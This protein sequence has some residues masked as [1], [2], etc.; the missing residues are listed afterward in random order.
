MEGRQTIKVSQEEIEKNICVS[1]C[2]FRNK[3]WKLWACEESV[4]GV[5]N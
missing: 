5:F 4:G 2:V 3:L 1:K